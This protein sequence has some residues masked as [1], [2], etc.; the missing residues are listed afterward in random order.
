MKNWDA[1]RWAALAKCLG[2]GPLRRGRFKTALITA[3]KKRERVCIK[4]MAEDVAAGLGEEY[5]IWA[6]EILLAAAKETFIEINCPKGI[7]NA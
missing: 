3:M 1:S 7:H 2:D 4:C 6:E 5:G